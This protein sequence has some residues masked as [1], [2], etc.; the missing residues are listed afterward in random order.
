MQAHQVTDLDNADDFENQTSVVARLCK[1][2]YL[3]ALGCVKGGYIYIYTYNIYYMNQTSV[4]ARLCKSVYLNT[5]GCV[6]GGY[7]YIYI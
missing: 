3:N 2:V 7:I 5:L 1:S 6:K 4:V